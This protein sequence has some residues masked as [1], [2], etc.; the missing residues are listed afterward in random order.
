MPL[1][2][3]GFVPSKRRRRV[4]FLRIGEARKILIRNPPPRAQ[5]KPQAPNWD[6]DKS[7]YPCLIT[8]RRRCT[9]AGKRG[10]RRNHRSVED[11]RWRS[12]SRLH[13][14]NYS[15]RSLRRSRPRN[16]RRRSSKRL[17]LRSRTRCFRRSGSSSRRSSCSRSSIF[18]FSNRSR[19]RLLPR[20]S[21]CCFIRRIGRRQGI[22]PS[23]TICTLTRRSF[24]CR[25]S[26]CF[27]PPL[28]LVFF[29]LGFR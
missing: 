3:P 13:H 6:P 4:F 22:I 20:S 16:N 2:K 14:P 5:I 23:G 27:L 10:R 1:T 24:F 29:L 9:V 7:R 11:R 26:M 19:R 21:S 17:N 18:S 12:P 8:A 15:S 25:S 28:L